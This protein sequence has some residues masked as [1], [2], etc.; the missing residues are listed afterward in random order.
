MQ[1]L[2]CVPFRSPFLSIRYQV[3]DDHRLLA[4]R[5]VDP[6]DTIGL[7]LLRD[8]RPRNGAESEVM[9]ELLPHRQG[10]EPPQPE[11]RRLLAQRLDQATA[12][13]LALA[14]LRDR[15][16]RH[17]APVRRTPPQ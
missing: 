15:E 7:E 14:P 6:L 8:L 4:R 13:P 3:E 11:R 5:P 16:R 1:A 12:D 10:E 17:L 2:R 9:E